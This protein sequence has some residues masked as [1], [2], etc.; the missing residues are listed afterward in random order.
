MVEPV[1]RPVPDFLQPEYMQVKVDGRVPCL[2]LLMALASQGLSL[3]N[4]RGDLVLT[5]RPEDFK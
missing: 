1:K 4:V 3:K 2:T 5:D